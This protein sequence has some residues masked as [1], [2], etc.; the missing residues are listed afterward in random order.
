MSHTHPL[1]ILIAEDDRVSALYLC[2]L[3]EKYGHQSRLAKNGNEVLKALG[4][5]Y[6]DIVLMDIQM[7][8]VDGLEATRRIRNSE[9]VF[10]TI[11]I[12]AVSANQD[13][14]ASDICLDAGMDHFIPKPLSMPLFEQVL[15]QIR[16][17]RAFA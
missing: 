16:S 6:F 17:K 14:P 12:I 3:L 2:K 15:W 8:E 11:P 4:N 1:K 13:P 9:D 7:P 5:E 10:S